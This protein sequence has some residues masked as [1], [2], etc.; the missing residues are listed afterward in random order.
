MVKTPYNGITWGFYLASS[1][2]QPRP[3]ALP[4]SLQLTPGTKAQRAVNERRPS[5]DAAPLE[6]LHEIKSKVIIRGLYYITVIQV[7][8]V[9]VLFGYK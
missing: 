9:K 7:I 4:T 5:P 3:E 2:M 1:K 6:T 8:Q